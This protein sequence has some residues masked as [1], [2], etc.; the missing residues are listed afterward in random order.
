[1]VTHIE[2]TAGALTWLIVGM[3]VT[4]TLF[5]HVDLFVSN[6]RHCLPALITKE[7]LVKIS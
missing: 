2:R 5:L 7:T 4:I 1:M 3:Y 6:G